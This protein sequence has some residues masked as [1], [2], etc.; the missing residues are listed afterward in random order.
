MAQTSATLCKP[1]GS[2]FSPHTALQNSR[3]SGQVRF[4]KDAKRCGQTGKDIKDLNTFV[5]DKIKETIKERNCNMH[6]MSNFKDLSISSS[7]Q[8]IISN[9]SV[10]DSDNN[11]CKQAHKK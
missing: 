5:K 8:S 4:V 11:S 1:A 6:A 7:I 3:G 9:T 10:E 2:T